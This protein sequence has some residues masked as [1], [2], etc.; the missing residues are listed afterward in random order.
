MNTRFA[1]L[2]LVATAAACSSPNTGPQA[3]CSAAS[4]TSVS[5]AVGAYAAIDPATDSGCI[6]FPANGTANSAEYLVVAQSAGGVPGDSAS[7][8][9]Q[10]ANISAS[11][12]AASTRLGQSR[13]VLVGRRGPVAM[14]FDRFLRERERAVRA[15]V[16]L[17]AAPLVVRA[18]APPAPGSL[19]TFSVCANYDCSVY[20]AVTG[21]V[22]S[23]GA[24]SA[25]YVDTLAPANGLDSAQV[26]SLRQVFDAHA[27]VVDTVAFGGVSD[28]DGNGIVLILMTPVVN[29]LV[30]AAQCSSGGFVAGFFDPSDLDP[31]TAAQHNDGEIFYTV[32]ADPNGALSCAHTTADVESFLPSTLVHELQHLIGFN[33]H[34]LLRG[35]DVEEIWLDEALSSLAEELAGRSFL[36][37]SDTFLQY[38]FNDLATAY[39][40]LQNPGAHFLLQTSDTALE[41]FGAG[42]LYAR[43]LVDQFG[44][45]LTT[46]LEQTALTGAVNVAT[47]TGLPFETTTTRWALANWVSDLPGFSPPAGVF[48]RSWSFRQVFAAFNAQ[49]PYD[50]PVAFP[51][52][53]P[54]TGSGGAPLNLSGELHAGSGYYVQIVQAPG[55]AALAVRFTGAPGAISPNV[56]ARLAVIR[57]Q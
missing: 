35:G 45:S 2:F 10:S 53:P 47:Q 42:W 6:A 24:H 36:P 1:W 15:A 52:V 37:D 31:S 19:R 9:L 8:A 12:V 44:A 13:H 7:F 57:I 22:R 39:A 11:L 28:L 41:D 49:D 30:S 14:R 27:Y 33:Q 50:F 23:V 17:N 5:L 25:I 56:D 26:D 32:V 3:Q 29:A 38:T 34:V 18:A 43:F 46:H 40:Y 4:A 48:Y 21:R 20:K 16:R 51:L 55:A 54:A